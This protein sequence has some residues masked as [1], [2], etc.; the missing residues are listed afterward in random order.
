MSP[1][2][3]HGGHHGL[4]HPAGGSNRGG[5]AAS[6]ATVRCRTG[7]VAGAILRRPATAS[8]THR[9]HPLILSGPR[10][11]RPLCGFIRLSRASRRPRPVGE[12]DRFDRTVTTAVRPAGPA[13]S[14]SSSRRLRPAHRRLGP[15]HFGAQAAAWDVGAEIRVW[16][17]FTLSRGGQA[18]RRDTGMPRL[19]MRLR[20]VQATLASVFCVGRVRAWRLRP[21]KVL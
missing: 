13:T 3:A 4:L 1:R 2:A 9:Q 8:G 6:R 19:V 10:R 12:P 5:P 11:R 18:I 7:A 21:I 14:R 15:C 17:D 16:S 20:T